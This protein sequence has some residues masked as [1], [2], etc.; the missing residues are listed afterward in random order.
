MSAPPPP[1]AA[2][3]MPPQGRASLCVFTNRSMPFKTLLAYCNRFYP[4]TWLAEKQKTGVRLPHPYVLQYEIV[5]RPGD[6]AEIRSQLKDAL[7]RYQI[8][9]ADS[10]G[11]G[12]MVW[13]RCGKGRVIRTVKRTVGWHRRVGQ[14]YFNQARSWRGFV[15]GV[16]SAPF[17]MAWLY[18][19]FYR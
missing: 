4:E 6:W 16:C 7:G 17:V 2:Q 19:L 18:W 14:R 9:C 13:L 10:G 15:R 12:D 8:P 3:A 11:D 5:I 1:P